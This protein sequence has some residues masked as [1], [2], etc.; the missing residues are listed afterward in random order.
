[1]Y[2]FFAQHTVKLSNNSE[3]LKVGSEIVL[4]LQQNSNETHNLKVKII[5]KK[6]AP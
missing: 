3:I 1:M 5:G 6:I 2:Q 4:K